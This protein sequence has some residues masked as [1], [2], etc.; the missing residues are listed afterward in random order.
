MEEH[1]HFVHLYLGCNS[2]MGKFVGINKNVLLIQSRENENVEY[3]KMQLGKELFLYL[4][5]L[6]SLTSNQSKEL[7]NQGIS[8][9]RPHGYTFSNKGFLYLLS[10]HVDLFGFIKSGI[11]KDISHLKT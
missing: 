11:A 10:L 6:E 4:R 8:I 5:K 3:Q 7:I 1:F 2:N 9:G